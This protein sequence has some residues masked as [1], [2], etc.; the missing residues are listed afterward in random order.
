MLIQWIKL[1]HSLFVKLF[2]CSKTKYNFFFLCTFLHTMQCLFI[3]P[4]C[5]FRQATNYQKTIHNVLWKKEVQRDSDQD[6]W[7]WL[8]DSQHR[9]DTTDRRQNNRLTNQSRQ[10]VLYSKVAQWKKGAKFPSKGSVF[11]SSTDHFFDTVC[12]ISVERSENIRDRQH[13]YTT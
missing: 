9:T 3:M 4:M 2:E 13:Y 11:G 7:R 5:F 6:N 1:R 10:N 8:T 12:I